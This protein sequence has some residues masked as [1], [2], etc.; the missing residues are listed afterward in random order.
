[1]EYSLSSSIKKLSVIDKPVIGFL[2]GHGEPPLQAFSQVLASLN[3]L[4][5]AESVT[6]NDSTPLLEK[7]ETV[8]LVAPTDSF[9][10]SHLSQLTQFIEQGNNL[11]VAIDRVV[12]D[13]GSATG[14]EQTTG[15]ESWLEKMGIRI[16]GNFMVDENCA[17]V[18]V[19]QQ[20]GM[21]TLSTNVNFPFIPVFSTFADHP[22]TTGLEAVLMQFP[23]SMIF[24][25]DSSDRF[26]PLVFSS[27]R[28]G[29]QRAPAFFDIQ[30]RWGDA[31]F[32]LSGLVA[33]AAL[34]K[35]NQGRLVV[36]ADGDFP[37]NGIGQQARQIQPDN[38]SLLVNAIDWLSD[39]TGLIEL[40]TRG[41]SSRPLDQIED[42]TKRF[43][44]YFNFLLPILLII[45][46]GVYRSQRNRSIKIRRMEDRYV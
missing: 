22:I 9:P 38:A 35:N 31:D 19:T 39:D 24:V 29:T 45:L 12:G 21:F 28:S 23:S 3:I 11:V 4:Y 43:L 37:V 25:G 7:Y 2:Q 41:V 6:L 18:T 8:V 42:G 14:R 15:L 10:R 30:R 34:V 44:K 40:R 17:P 20:Q 5:R 27:N 16:E 26:V 46:Y 33:G 36:F 13:L 32:P 1:M